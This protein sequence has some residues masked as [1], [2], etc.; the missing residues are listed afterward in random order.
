M[1]YVSPGVYVRELDFSLYVPTLSSTICGMVGTTTKGPVNEPTLITT[2]PAFIK[3]FGSPSPDHYLP[4]AA[5]QYLRRGKQLWVV[6][7]AGSTSLAASATVNAYTPGH[8]VSTD[9]D[10]VFTTTSSTNQLRVVVTDERTD[11][12][13]TYDATVTL[14]VLTSATLAA[15]VADVANKLSRTPLLSETATCIA[16][17]GKLAIVAR[18]ASPS[19][20]I[21]VENATT[22]SAAAALGLPVGVLADPTSIT[23]TPQG[24]P[25][26]TT[27]SYTVVAK[28]G[29]S[30]A[31]A[32]AAQ[33]TTSAATL[34]VT[35]FNRIAFTAP[36]N[37][38]IDIYRTDGSNIIR[39]AS[40]LAATATQFDDTGASPLG[41][42][43]AAVIPTDRAAVGVA[44]GTFTLKASSVGTHGNLLKV[45]FT[46]KDQKFDVAI[47][48]GTPQNTAGYRT[49]LHKDVSLDDSS[50]KW[51][52]T[53]LGTASTTGSSTSLILDTE[54]LATAD[55]LA[56]PAIGTVTLSG[57]DDGLVSV[58]SAD[59]IGV[60]AP[61]RTGLQCFRSPDEIDV[62]LICVPGITAPSVINEMLGLCEE[63]GDAMAIIDTPDN[64]TVQQVVDW[65]NGQGAFADHQAFNSSYGAMYWPWIQ[66]YDPYNGVEVWTPP[67]GHVAAIYAYTDFIAETW[68]APAGFNRAHI[69]AGLKVRHSASH[70]EREHLYGNQNAV[71]P[72]VSF[73]KDG[74]TVWGQRTLQRAPTALD[75]VNVRRLL[76]YMRKVISTAVKYL[77]FEP[78]DA[79]TW[80][81]FFRLVNPFC[82]AIK[83]RR[84]LYDFRIVCDESTNTP[85]L[86]DNNTM[87]GVIMLKP[88][89]TAEIIQVD[90]ALAPT[91]A[92]FKELEELVF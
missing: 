25:G 91:G 50:S 82:E 9:S 30:I 38:L 86:I 42:A 20:K 3:I 64:Y 62:N 14:S 12:V 80:R 19:V 13:T 85:D 69:V 37:S 45:Q 57:G 65:H 77:L 4:Y 32:A 68:F 54:T 75:R 15:T 24:T 31:A 56:V 10:Q 72:I 6:R 5:L 73:P 78:N 27:V 23:V 34:N 49:E 71:N 79:A 67:S 74:I 11:P 83:N 44:A 60:N 22:N 84:G 36:A 63:R 92:S 17:G 58:I 70:G 53:V 87:R 29:T 7:V 76:L 48:E 8:V 43:G 26:S 66:I 2:V 90:F 40:D 35:N 88:T 46:Q 89:K 47:F 55:K 61:T 16:V 52:G 18:V 41:T 51:V 59:Y 39:V 33:T 21:R 81:Q 1:K 28:T